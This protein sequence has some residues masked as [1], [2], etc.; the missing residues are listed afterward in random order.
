[1]LKQDNWRKESLVRQST[2]GKNMNS[3]GDYIVVIRYQAT[4]EHRENLGT[5][6]TGT[7]GVCRPGCHS[8][9]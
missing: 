6:V 8:Y 5:M 4:R 7:F 1:M 2:I 9:L 3:K